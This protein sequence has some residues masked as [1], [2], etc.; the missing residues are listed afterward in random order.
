VVQGL[1]QLNEAITQGQLSRLEAQK[2]AELERVGNNAAAREAIEIR[3]DKKQAEIEA[4]AQQRRKAIAIADK[5]VAIS[6]TIVN[7]AQGISKTIAQLGFPAA[8]PFVVLAG[9][10]GAL[11]I[12]TIAAQKFEQGG[13]LPGA[14]GVPDGAS[15]SGG[16]IVLVERSTGRVRGEIE[17]GEPILSRET[18]ANNREVVDRLLYS[19]MRQ[20]GA[21]IMYE[22][23]GILAAPSTT[24][25]PSVVERAAQFSD[26]N[27]VRGLQ[28]VR[29]AVRQVKLMIGEKEAVA[30][31]RLADGYNDRV[32]GTGL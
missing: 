19:S 24:P 8:I 6:N 25:L 1:D 11:Q 16:G 22:D 2:Q 13:V 26:A 30:M 20:G 12:A 14:G 23:G 4:K 18:Y 17:G 5:G 31:Q 32:S 28:E 9:A 10:S 27:I 7:T 15:H 3:Y 21:R 29:D